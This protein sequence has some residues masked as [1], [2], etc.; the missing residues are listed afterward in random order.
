MKSEAKLPR[1]RILKS[2]AEIGRIFKKGIWIQGE[3]LNLIISPL[4][5]F[6]KTG[7][8]LSPKFAVLVNKKCGRAVK[9]NRL[10]RIAREFFRSNRNLFQRCYAV[11]FSFDRIVDDEPS[12]KKEM[13]ELANRVSGN[14]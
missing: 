3:Y 9:R 13:V 5:M 2:R 14:V 10:K 12:L 8:R 6:E 7:N 11:I 1:S 4:G